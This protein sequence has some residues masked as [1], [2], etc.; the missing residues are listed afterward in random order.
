[1]SKGAIR[2][3]ARRY[4]E[5]GLSFIVRVRLAKAAERAMSDEGGLRALGAEMITHRTYTMCTCDACDEWIAEWK[6]GDFTIKTDSGY[7][8]SAVKNQPVLPSS[9]G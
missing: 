7:I 3:R 8:V 9:E 4:R 6:L 2:R 1:V 5:H